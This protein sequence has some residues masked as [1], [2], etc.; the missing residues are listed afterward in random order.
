MG[1]AETAAAAGTQI[2]RSGERVMTKTSPWTWVIIG[3]VLIGL[4]VVGGI[5]VI[6]VLEPVAKA[7]EAGTDVV[8]TGTDIWKDTWLWWCDVWGAECPESRG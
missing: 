2:A 7:A 1:Q 3:G 8:T 6:K 4:T 5:I